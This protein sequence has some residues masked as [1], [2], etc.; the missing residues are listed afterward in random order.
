ML[1]SYPLTR[2]ESGEYV[3]TLPEGRFVVGELGRAI[4]P[5]VFRFAEDEAEYLR[6]RETDPFR[7]REAQHLGWRDQGFD[8]G[9]PLSCLIDRDGPKTYVIVSRIEW[10][11]ERYSFVATRCLDLSPIA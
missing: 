11:G 3:L 10:Q 8:P 2:T 5:E 1:E 7:M 6:T 9:M 4:L